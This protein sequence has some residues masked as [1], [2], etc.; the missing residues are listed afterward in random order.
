M[1]TWYII[2]ALVVAALALW[3]VFGMKQTTDTGTSAIEQTQMP[4]L[5]GGD[6]T[7]DITADLGAV[8]SSAALDAEAAASAQD[9]QSL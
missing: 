5:S 9:V 3:F 4:A 6:T 2:G 1:K 8:D 7:A